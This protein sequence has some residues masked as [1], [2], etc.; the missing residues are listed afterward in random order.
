MPTEFQ[1]AA[2]NLT[3]RDGKSLT[4]AAPLDNDDNYVDNTRQRGILL[5][6]NDD[7]SNDVVVHILSRA[8][9]DGYPVKDVVQTVA[10]NGGKYAFGPFN[11]ANWAT[12][13]NV[14]FNIYNSAGP[15]F[16]NTTDVASGTKSVAGVTAAWI[17]LGSV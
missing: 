17:V 6:F 10:A 11:N 15:T 7:A 5:V 3:T 13:G 12:D 1:T 8:T 14:T 2:L 4:F 9:V 16:D